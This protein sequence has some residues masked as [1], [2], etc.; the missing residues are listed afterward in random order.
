M[1]RKSKIQCLFLPDRLIFEE[2]DQVL[3][4]LGFRNVE[5]HVVAWK[6]GIGVGE[7][8]VE[9]DFVPNDVS[10][11]QCGRVDEVGRLA[12]GATKDSAKVWPFAVLIERV[13]AGAAF[14]KDEFAL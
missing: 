9:G 1:A 12:G 13:A 5:V 10:I 3:A 11:F 7:P 8:P 2:E 4:F 6:K 14:F